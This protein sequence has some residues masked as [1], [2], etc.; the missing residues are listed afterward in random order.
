M[1]TDRLLIEE[2]PFEGA[3]DLGTKTPDCEQD[4]E[5]EVNRKIDRVEERAHSFR[6]WVPV[7]AYRA[8]DDPARGL[9]FTNLHT[10]LPLR[11]SWSPLPL[12]RKRGNIDGGADRN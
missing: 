9:S 8:A 3:K 7:N 2:V 12:D 1:N 5:Y 6:D 4:N 11:S 10:L